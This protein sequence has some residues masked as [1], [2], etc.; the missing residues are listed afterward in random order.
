MS[1][2]AVGT[3]GRDRGRNCAWRLHQQRFDDLC[4][5]LHQL[6]WQRGMHGGVRWT[7]RVQGQEFS[8]ET[9][10]KRC[11]AGDHVD[12][13]VPPNVTN[14]VHPVQREVPDIRPIVVLHHIEPPDYSARVCVMLA[15]SQ[16]VFT[17]LL[18]NWGMA[19]AG[20]G[21]CCLLGDFIG[22]AVRH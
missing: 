5:N 19:A 8:F 17:L 11:G 2:L 14:A 22:P 7:Q 4:I 18:A 12:L 1:L 9:G 10:V 3:N 21:W 13:R 6:G 20:T 16:L 15:G